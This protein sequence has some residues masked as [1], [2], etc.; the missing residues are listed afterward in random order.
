MILADGRLILLTEKGDLCLVE[1]TPAA[2]R[3]TAR[4]RL[5]DA[6][7]CRTHPALANGR[8]YARDQKKLVCIDLKK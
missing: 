3:E 8:L 1:A 6:G 4:V 7:P 2:L 5:F